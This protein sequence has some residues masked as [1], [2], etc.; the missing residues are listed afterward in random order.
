M[1]LLGNSV[2]AVNG[3]ATFTALQVFAKPG[4]WRL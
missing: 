3:T 2:R 4:E 1:A